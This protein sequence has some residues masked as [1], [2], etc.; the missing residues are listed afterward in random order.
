MTRASAGSALVVGA[1]L[2]GR[3]HAHALRRL[4]IPI[5]GIVDTDGER[6]SRLARRVG[7]R[8]VHDEVD[9]ALSEGG[10]GAAHV[11]TP[12]DTHAALITRFF[13]AG[14]HVLCEKPLAGTAAETTALLDSASKS[15][16][17]L[18]PVHQ[19][20]FQPGF[21]R[22]VAALAG[23]GRLLHVDFFAASA[24]AERGGDG[25]AEA[26]AADILPH[27]LSLLRRLIGPAFGGIEWHVLRR[28]PGEIRIVG[29]WDDATLGVLVSMHGRP[30]RNALRLVFDEG[31]WHVDL[32]HGFAWRED[33]GVSRLRKIGR[34]FGA[35]LS[36]GL[37]ATANL[38]RRALSREPAYP[39]LRTLVGKFWE[40][41]DRGAP[42]PIS[43]Q[44]VIDVAEARDALSSTG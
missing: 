25:L 20:L 42:P 32:F 5:G 10:Y 28:S 43:A 38:G 29:A 2:M 19:F 36:S 11:C 41:V 34:P 44:E 17:L 14:V 23:S 22:V 7:A 21:L 4:S 12:A 1:G 26:V 37:A 24:G 30:T 3:W 39:G 35:S 6:A 16:R 40:S 27:P 31:T 8:R 9:A 15:G 13:D 33:P 18:V